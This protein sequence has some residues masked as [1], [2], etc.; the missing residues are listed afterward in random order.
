MG[1][2]NEVSGGGFFFC[3]QTKLA[4][5]KAPPPWDFSR[6][7][8]QL[9]AVAQAANNAEV[10]IEQCDDDIKGIFT[11][12]DLKISFT[13]FFLK[14]NSHID[15][16]FFYCGKGPSWV[17]LG[18]GALTP[19]RNTKR[20]SKAVKRIWFFF[21]FWSQ[22][23]SFGPQSPTHLYGIQKKKQRFPQ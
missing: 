12:C 13:F 2:Q 11:A 5:K 10:I 7:L 9:G 21:A 19:C 20:L 17:P 14:A 18:P 1:F 23:G 3:L 16:F 22:P 8:P 6:A 15:F 4:Q